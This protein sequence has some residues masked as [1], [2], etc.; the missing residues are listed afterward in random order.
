MATVKV[1]C[2]DND[3]KITNSIDI[4]KVNEVNN[5]DGVFTIDTN[6]KMYFFP[7]GTVHHIEASGLNDD[8]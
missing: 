5:D 7:H 3:G 2:V 8:E 1:H 6:D 4:D